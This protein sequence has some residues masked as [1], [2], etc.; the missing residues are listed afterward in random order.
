MNT[1]LSAVDSWGMNT[2][3]VDLWRER[4]DGCAPVADMSGPVR[5]GETVYWV[6][7]HTHGVGM[8]VVENGTVW[9]LLDVKAPAR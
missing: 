8:V 7:G 9:V 4:R 5:D 6:G 3:H 2:V 1:S